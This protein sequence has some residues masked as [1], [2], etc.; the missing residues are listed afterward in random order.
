LGRWGQPSTTGLFVAGF[1]LLVVFVFIERRVAEPMID[2]ALF[3]I[4]VFWAGNSALFLNALSRGAT[5]YI[6]SWYFQAVLQNSPLAAGLKMLPLAVTM[7]VSAPLAGRLSDKLPA[8]ELATVGLVGTAVAM[9]WMTTFPVDVPYVYLA[10]ALVLMGLSN[11]FFNAP[12]TTAVMG[13]V[14]AHRRGIASGTR[15]LLVNSGQTI[16]IALTMAIVATTMSYQTL[17]TLFSGTAEAGQALD[18]V[19]FMDGLHKV[20]LAGAVMSIA[21]IICSAM[22]GKADWREGLVETAAEEHPALA[23]AH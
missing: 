14:P 18:A 9:L 12:N 16:A 1:A 23:V 15:T 20:F 10:I 8:R 22:R 19:A 6:M 13:S 7:A 3:K 17:V 2:P 21:A 11:T 4:R 5:M